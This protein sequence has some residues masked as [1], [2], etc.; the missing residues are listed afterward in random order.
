MNALQMCRERLRALNGEIR[1]I[2]EAC[3]DQDRDLLA[4]ESRR[5]TTLRAERGTLETRIAQLEDEERREGAQARGRELVGASV[6]GG[7][8]N[9]ADTVYQRGNGFS[10]FRDLMATATP[11]SSEAFEAQQ[12]LNLHAQCIDRAAAD[13]PKEFRA[14]PCKRAAG[15]ETR[16]VTRVD[17]AGGYFV[18][19]LWILDEYAA[20]LRAGRATAD[21]CNVLDLPPGTDSI[22]LPKVNTGTTTAVQT[23][24]A[25]AVSETDLTDTSI[26]GPV[27]TIAGQNDI[28]L[29]LMEQS[30]IAFDEVIFQDL[31]ADYNMQ[32]DRQV[33]S[34][35]GS[36]GQ[37]KGI[38]N[39]GLTA[40]TYTDATPTVPELYTP[41]TQALSQIAKARFLP[42]DT[43][44]MH[45][46]RWYW[47]TSALDTQ[48]RPLVTPE[49]GGGVNTIAVLDANAVE[50]VVGSIGGVPIVADANMTTGYGAGSNQDRILVGRLKDAFLFEGA[51][52][53]RA[54]V[55]VM[56]GTLLVRC[57]LYNY[58][59][60]IADRYA[61][62]YASIDG[63]GCITPSGW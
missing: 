32:L 33:L 44:V 43:I 9:G 55:E 16:A 7:L 60:L 41:L 4:S 35:S 8:G 30:G 15:A 50:G 42:G 57:Q 46:S 37:V 28:A 62:S 38:F 24:D 40:V 22:N 27:R 10:Y 45:P 1:A 6:S 12:R 47:I 3:E 21:R 61:V 26:S 18:A 14:G 49:G 19:P 39:A 5:F 2:S 54:L 23:A 11:G 63:T 34:G 56:S 52:R 53:T 13:L 31:T 20:M 58:V 25:A 29:Q 48:N 17:G 36:S 59:A 51:L